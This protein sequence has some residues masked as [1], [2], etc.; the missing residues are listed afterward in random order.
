MACSLYWTDACGRVQS[1]IDVVTHPQLGT[2]QP[3]VSERCRDLACEVRCVQVCTTQALM[4]APESQWAELLAGG[5][6]TPVP[7]LPETKGS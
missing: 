2:S 1:L 5:Q 7:V 3:L 4:S 6:W